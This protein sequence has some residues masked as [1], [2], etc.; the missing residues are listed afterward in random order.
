[1]EPLIL[2][3]VVLAIVLV[4]N[5]VILVKILGV[6]RMLRTPEVKKLNPDF[7]KQGRRVN[8]QDVRPGQSRDNRP[9]Q[10]PQRSS[11]PGSAPRP[12][13][14]T[15]EQGR[16]G[17]RDNRDG[18][19]DRNRD[20]R[21]DRDRNRDGRGDRDRNRDGRGDRDRNRDGRGDRSRRP[22]MQS[23]ESA[24]QV[25]GSQAYASELGASVAQSAPAVSE[26]QVQRPSFEGRRPLEPRT[27][28]PEVVLSQGSLEAT[29]A[30]ES[31][32]TESADFDPSRMRHGRRTIVRKPLLV[33][34]A[35]AAPTTGT[36]NN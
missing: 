22:E 1:M 7:N 3:L 28:E 9:Q 34:E 2:V 31:S 36:P 27:Q 17:S 20:G 14:G 6:T 35:P 4:L 13:G 32:A 30:P 33:D 19:V 26:T 15:P 5:L 25:Q 29:Q 21:G 11:L 16:D 12:Q 24:E 23:N 18:R 10:N 8:L